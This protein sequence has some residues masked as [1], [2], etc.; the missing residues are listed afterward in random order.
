MTMFFISCNVLRT[1]ALAET[2]T[3]ICRRWVPVRCASGPSTCCGIIHHANGDI[4][5]SEKLT[6]RSLS[7]FQGY[8]PKAVLLLSFLPRPMDFAL[9]ET[10]IRCTICVTEFIVDNLNRLSFFNRVERQVMFHGHGDNDQ[11]RRDSAFARTILCNSGLEVVDV[12]GAPDWGHDCGNLQISIVGPDAHLVWSP[13]FSRTPN[14]KMWTQLSRCIIPAIAICVRRKNSRR[15]GR[16]LHQ[17]GCR[18]NGSATARGD[19]QTA[20]PGSGPGGRV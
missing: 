3:A 17:L 4:E 1:V 16:A 20:S 12:T 15:R 5:A 8:D 18:G 13:I 14:W 10:G 19:L 6:A 7:K 2:I 11:A 9:S